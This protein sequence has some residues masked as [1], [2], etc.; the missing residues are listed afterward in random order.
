VWN[1]NGPQMYFHHLMRTRYLSFVLSVGLHC[2][3]GI[4]LKF[5]ENLFT[6]ATTAPAPAT[7]RLT[8]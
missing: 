2:E 7:V 8:V 1:S 3:Y 6:V 4:V 5:S